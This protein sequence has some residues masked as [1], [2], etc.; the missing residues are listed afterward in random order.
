MLLMWIAPL[1]LAVMTMRDSTCQPSALITFYFLLLFL[2]FLLGA[3]IMGECKF[4]ICTVCG[5][6]LG[7]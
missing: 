7:I 6:E 4:Y 5:L 2:K 1:I 3:L